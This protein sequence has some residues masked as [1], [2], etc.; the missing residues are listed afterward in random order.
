M[1]TNLFLMIKLSWLVVSPCRLCRTANAVCAHQGKMGLFVNILISNVW[2]VMISLLY[3]GHN[4]LLSCMMVANE[5]FGFATHRKTL[6]VSAPRGIQRSSYT[7]SM[8]LRYGIP[9]MLIFSME[10]WILS[11][12]TFIVR[13]NRTD[14]QGNSSYGWTT[15]GYSIIPC[16]IGTVD[17]Y[18]YLCLL[19]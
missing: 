15:S 18:P 9:M 19:H 14:Y 11:Q 2:Q 17:P 7:L 12:A 10:H 16:I 1:L 13:V 3:I 8:P 4:A 5:W 6:R